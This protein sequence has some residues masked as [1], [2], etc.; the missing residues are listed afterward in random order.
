MSTQSLISR[1]GRLTIFMIPIGIAINFV[2]GQLALL[3]KLPVY[4]DSIGT[5]LVGALC[6]GIPG[7]LVGL[8]SN[9]INS[10]TSPPTLAFGVLS[11]I[12]GLL[13]GWLGK[14]GVFTVFWKTLASAIPFALIGGVLGALITLWVFG[15][16]AVGGGALVVGALMAT[17]MDVTTANFVAQVPMDFLD[18]VPTVLAVFVV[19]RGIPRRIYAKLPLG[20]VY[21]RARGVTPAPAFTAS[22][23]APGGQM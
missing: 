8:I 23:P 18:K 22:R 4:L 13:A 5:I 17:G 10:I 1:Y 21:L 15:G 3:L 6:G 14:R 20:E 19:L 9:G 2:G 16:L 12:F 11:V 7:A